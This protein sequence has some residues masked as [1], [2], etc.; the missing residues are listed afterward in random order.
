VKVSRFDHIVLTVADIDTTVDF[1]TRVL[2][3]AVVTFGGDRKALSFGTSKI[4]LHRSGREFE[5]KAHRPTPGSAD[6]CLVVDDD[7]DHVIAQ[8][9]AA[10]VP[11]EEGPVE[12]TGANG[13]IMSVYVRDPDDN[14]IELSNYLRRPANRSVPK[15]IL[16][17]TADLT[18]RVGEE[19]AVSDWIPVTQQAINE[20]AALTGDHQW[21]HVDVQK[22]AASPFGGTIAHGLF[23]LSL[24]PGLIDQLFAVEGFSAGLN[25]G[26]N[27]VRLPAPLPVGASVRMRAT[28]TD[29]QEV[30]GGAQITITQTFESDRGDKP[31]CVAEALTRLLI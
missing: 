3:M 10:R 13:P 27:K 17:G 19:L 21:I 18:S 15:T 9:H 24:G 25:Y 20:F 31:V 7:L 16:R 30:P 11:I 22:A 28:L 12:R 14:L 6:I 8:L 1:Y 23:T 5:P 29:V 2:G 4:N 26:Y